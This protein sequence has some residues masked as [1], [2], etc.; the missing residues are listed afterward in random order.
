[1]AFE[2]FNIENWLYTTLYNDS[3]LK[4]LLGKAADHAKNFQ[5]GVYAYVAPEIDP[6]S[7]TTPVLPYIVFQR[8]GNQQKDDL[9]A[10][11]ST[12]LSYPNY[13]ITIW[14]GGTKALAFKNI[15]DIADRVDTL[16]NNV[17]NNAANPP[18]NCL[19]QN[20]DTIVQIADDGKIYY[21]AVLEYYFVNRF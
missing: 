12:A 15:K 11:G 4:T 13:R 21:A 20:T 8:N 18:F 17:I 7:K 9:S 5:I 16:L 2:T 19:R 14:S 6:V 3:T 10:C 1:M